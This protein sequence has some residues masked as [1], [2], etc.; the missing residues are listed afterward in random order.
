MSAVS[1]GRVHS[2]KATPATP[3]TK[4]RQRC[5]R[6][7]ERPAVHPLHRV[8][9]NRQGAVGTRLHRVT[10]P[11]ESGVPSVREHGARGH[12]VH[13]EHRADRPAP[14][15]FHAEDGRQRLRSQRRDDRRCDQGTRADQRGSPERDQEATC[16]GCDRD[17]V[18]QV[19]P[20]AGQHHGSC[21]RRDC[22]KVDPPSGRYDYDPSSS[23]SIEVPPFIGEGLLC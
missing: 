7:G 19:R 23:A 16:R 22:K 1:V 2:C 13:R 6:R 14:V 17:R 10:H 12:Q 3:G 8:S 20:A 4:V 11:V 18:R 9:G 15:S 5:G 21:D